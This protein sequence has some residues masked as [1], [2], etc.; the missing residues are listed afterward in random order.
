MTA[1]PPSEN[2]RALPPP[3]ESPSGEVLSVY[4]M[5]RAAVDSF[6]PFSHFGT[7]NAAF[8]RM[9]QKDVMADSSPEAYLNGTTFYAVQLRIKNPLVVDDDFTWDSNGINSATMRHFDTGDR[10]YIDAVHTMPDHAVR[11]ELAQGQ[12]YGIGD[13]AADNK[14]HLARQR[15]VAVIEAKGYDGLAYINR[16]EDIGSVSWVNFRP[17]QVESV[18]SG[19]MTDKPCVVLPARPRSWHENLTAAFSRHADAPAAGLASLQGAR[20]ESS[21]QTVAGIVDH[22]ADIEAQWCAEQDLRERQF[23]AEIEIALYDPE[24]VA[25]RVADGDTAIAAFYE[26]CQQRMSALA[27]AD[28]EDLPSW[29]RAYLPDIKHAVQD[30]AARSAAAQQIPA[31]TRK[32]A[33]KV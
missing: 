26:R 17:Q 11:A 16:D 10:R 22:F 3:L 6:A 7:L 9:L 31:P 18:Y 15:M 1:R 21:P 29:Q 28:P 13:N 24:Y 19:P 14:R 2:I 32:P 30:L 12:L 33:I 27:A 8:E 5:G 25:S 4:H 20:F 23:K